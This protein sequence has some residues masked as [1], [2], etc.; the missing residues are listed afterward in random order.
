[1][2]EGSALRT[3]APA[4]VPRAS[5]VRWAAATFL[6]AAATLVVALVLGHGAPHSEPAGIPTPGAVT[7]WGLPVIGLAANVAGIATVGLLLA[8]VLLVPSPRGELTGMCLRASRA[9]GWTALVWAVAPLLLVVLTV[10]DIFAVPLREAFSVPLLSE[11]VRETSTGQS[12]VVQSALALV[13]CVLSRW[14]LTVR[15][16]ALLLGLAVATLVPPLLTGHSAS[17]G[18]HHLAT[19]SLLLHVVGASL[20]IGGL[21]A[22]GWISVAGSRRLP[23]GVLRFSTLA[24]WCLATVVASGVVNAAIRLGGVSELFTTAYGGLVMV[25]VAAAAG[26]GLLGWTHRRRIVP[27]LARRMADDR[28]DRGAAGRAFAAIAAVELTVMAMT[29]AVAVALSRTPT[30]VGDELV[31]PTTELLGIELPPAP[32]ALRLLVGLYP[33]G[34][35]IA[36]VCL[37][38]A[39]YVQG[40]LVLRRRGVEWS[41]GRTAAWFGGLVLVG[42]ATFGGLG[43]YSH[44]LFSAHMVSHMVLSMVAPIL[45]VLGA[46][47]TLALRTLPGP[48][49][50]GEVGPRQLLLSLL[51]SPPVRLLTHPLVAAGLFIV[52]LYAIYFSGLFDVLMGHDIGHAAMELHFLAVGSLFFYV[53]VGVDPGPRRVPQLV[54]FAVLIFVLPFHAFFAVA[55]MSSDTVIGAT[56]WTSLDRP[57]RTDLLD[58]QYLGGGIAWAMGELPLVLVLAALFVQWYRS[59]RRDAA[60]HDRTAART[61]SGH[62]EDEALDRYNSYLARL[63]EHDGVGTPARLGDSPEPSVPEGKG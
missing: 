25:K 57:Y 27:G 54:R 4:T 61:A 38:A 6:L 29:V 17:A 15:E 24:A 5:V 23:D 18:Y 39:L 43:L 13:V 31:G 33:D 11:F 21:L 45:L 47:L 42:W 41:P 20:W 50:P 26:L 62:D 40:L 22:L 53:L 52:S 59:D 12:L 2:P 63:A 1:M 56:Y 30:Q 14:T 28:L 16:G 48:R 35:G 10:S 3:P 32:S 34:V 36:L 19:V 44:V 55:L 9:A 51:H 60:R 46:P 58:D 37:A 7:G 49:V 8:A